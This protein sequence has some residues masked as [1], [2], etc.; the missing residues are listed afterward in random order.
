MNR[1][2]ATSIYIILLILN[3]HCNEIVGTARS[4]SEF[5]YPE[6][7]NLKLE[8]TVSDTDRL[9]NCQ[10]HG[11]GIV[12]LDVLES[13]VG[14]YMPNDSL[15]NYF[16]KINYKKAELYTYVGD[17]E[18]GDTVK[19]NMRAERELWIYNLRKNK[20]RNYSPRI[21]GKRFYEYV[22]SN[23]YGKL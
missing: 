8:A 4:V 7:E 15:E 18:I 5:N 22:K 2:K 10:C 12:Y 17:M 1:V 9:I 3:F 19:V 23:N 20:V 11:W 16:L 14:Y 21:Y 6:I 13:N